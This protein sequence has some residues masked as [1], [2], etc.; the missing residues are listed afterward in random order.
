MAKK[1][2]A[3]T[4]AFIKE[5]LV[6]LNATQAAIRAGY[7]KK[8]ARQV[9]SKMLT[10]SYIQREV[11]KAMEKRSKEIDIDSKFVLG[12]LQELALR[13]MQKTPV[14]RFDQVKKKNVQ[15]T[16]TVEHEDGT[17]TEEG[18]WKFDSYG[19][20]KALAKLG[21]HL[22]LFKFVLSNDPDNPVPCGVIILPNN[23]RE[24]KN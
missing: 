4:R 15:V 19:A 10:K 8:S 6:D 16:E 18:V 7:G 2:R 11:G 21:E 12:N 22:G 17:T 5:Y 13:C 14:M 1:L 24:G 3:K 9:A 20:N 23:K